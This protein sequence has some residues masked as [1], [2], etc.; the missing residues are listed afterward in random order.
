M[1]AVKGIFSMIPNSR[2]SKVIG[3]S[4]SKL[5]YAIATILAFALPASSVNYS[6]IFYPLAILA[7]VTGALWLLSMRTLD[8]LS[9]TEGLMLLT[10]SAYP[11]AAFLEMQL[12]SGWHWGWFQEPSRFLLV[13]PLFLMLRHTGFMESALKWGVWLGAIWAGSWALYQNFYL[14]IQRVWG[15][16]S[17][18]IN[19]FGDI[20]LILGVMSIALFHKQWRQDKRWLVV[21]L[22]AFGFGAYGSLASGA[23][24]GWISVP[25]LVWILAGLLPQPTIKKRVLLVAMA[26]VGFAL[27]VYFVPFI[28]QRIEMIVPAI[29]QYSSTGIIVEGSVGIR[30]GLWHSAFLTFLDN[31]LFGTGAGTFHSELLKDIE[32]GLM[33]ARAGAIAGAHSQFFESLVR[34][35]VFGP[36]L[37][38]SIFGSFIY[39]C[40]QGLVHNPGLATAGILM[41]V[42]FIGFGM[43]EHIWDINNA[44]VFYALM[45]AI[46]AGGLS[47]LKPTNEG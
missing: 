22:L 41:A 44:G 16:T 42:G 23:K 28:Y 24:G 3:S 5:F 21:A 40:K 13:M 30:L 15:G 45:M 20:S 14:G 33:N 12:R 4:V 27:V 11:L 1:G 37:I 7:V 9:K 39:H 10:W 29:Y 2:Y 32:M 31:P 19:A 47:A 36:L 17:G 34:F 26:G 25:F 18:L 46:I 6:S 35:G 43:V 8:P 38:F